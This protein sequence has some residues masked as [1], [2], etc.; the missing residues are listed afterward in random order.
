MSDKIDMVYDLVKD[1]RDDQI[2]I[3]DIQSAWAEHGCP[4]GR[5]TADKVTNHESRIRKIEKTMAKAVAA[6]LVLASGTYGGGKLIELL[7]GQ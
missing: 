5:A 3:R 1:I 6:G 7:L 2:K 4:T